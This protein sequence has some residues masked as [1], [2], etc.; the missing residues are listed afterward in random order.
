MTAHIEKQ[1]K[2]HNL[3][4]RHTIRS[5]IQNYLDDQGFIAIDAPLLVKGTTP[6]P[7]IASFQ[8]GDHYLTTS[9]EY[10]IKRIVSLGL[11]KVYTLT[12]NF[13][14]ESP[15]KMHNPEFTMLEWAR[16]GA[17]LAD[18]EADAEGM[19]T[20]ALQA[21]NLPQELIYQGQT[22]NLAPP[23]KRLTVAE[24]ISASSGITINKFDIPTLQSALAGICIQLQPEWAEDVVMLFTLLLD[25]AQKS[26]GMDT[27]VFLQ[28]WPTFLTSSALEKSEEIT[29]RSEL[30]IAGIEI[31]DGFPSL[32][33]PQKQKEAFA[34]QLRR[35]EMEKLPTVSLDQRY[36]AALE[37]GLPSGAG[38]AL[39]FDRLV[40]LLTDSQRIADVMPFS[41]DE[42]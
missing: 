42:L 26:L 12:Q 9:T 2:I 10:H 3:R 21:L 7:G 39:G 17:P 11:E 15:G 8:V 5:V 33:D 40:M 13:R 22:I 16:V 28:D 36:I 30:F 41:W 19:V 27:P 38:M 4:L 14:D 29:I 24:A 25:H 32:T 34:R 6:D 31:S 18:I 23:W 1:R 37:T 35:R 20:A